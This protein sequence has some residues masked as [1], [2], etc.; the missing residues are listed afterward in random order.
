MEQDTFPYDILDTGEV[1]DDIDFASAIDS[2][3]DITKYRLSPPRKRMYEDV[4]TTGP[5]RHIGSPKGWSSSP[6]PLPGDDDPTYT[7]KD[8]FDEEERY[9]KRVERDVQV[10]EA[11][12]PR[13]IP[14]AITKRK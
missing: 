8:L 12:R 3:A 1:I 2:K 9:M 13:D 10:I 5:M 14:L 6:E 11:L 7:L 4:Y